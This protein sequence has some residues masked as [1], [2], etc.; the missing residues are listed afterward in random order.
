MQEKLN[1]LDRAAGDGDC[2]NTHARA[3]IGQCQGPGTKNSPLSQ[4]KTAGV[5]GKPKPED[6]KPSGWGE[7]GG[8]LCCASDSLQEA[9]FPYEYKEARRS[10]REGHECPPPQSLVLIWLNLEWPDPLGVETGSPQPQPRAGTPWQGD[11]WPCMSW[12]L[13]SPLTLWGPVQSRTEAL[14][15]GVGKGS[16]PWFCLC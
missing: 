12:E 4:S 3:A 13:I 11:Q 10:L 2:G 7:G 8:R 1:E 15:L 16:L 14:S 9:A 6:R 5:G